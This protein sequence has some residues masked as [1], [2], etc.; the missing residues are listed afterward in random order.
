VTER[1]PAD[2]TH[3]ASLGECLPLFVHSRRLLVRVLAALANLS[4][5]LGARNPAGLGITPVTVG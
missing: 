2:V 4:S 5:A 1:M 3:F